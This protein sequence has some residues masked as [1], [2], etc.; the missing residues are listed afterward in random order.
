M[1]IT[2]RYANASDALMIAAFSR[3]SFYET[4]APENTKANMD[5]F[6]NEQFTTEKLVAEVGA[7]DNIFLLA[8][9]GREIVGYARLRL[10]NKPPELNDA[11][12]LEIARIYASTESI[13]KG[14]GK[15]LMQNCLE[16]AAK[17]NK[18]TVWLGVWENNRR[19]IDFYKKWGFE[20]FSTH[21][22]MLG[23]DAQTDW[24]MKREKPPKSP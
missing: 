4:F 19:A 3:R 20:K 13:G 1:D 12:T 24:L 11:E 15:A 6:M 22:F 2:I 8:T 5:K 10:N 21:I 16:L 18:D 7:P 17:L 23:D 9:S 14:I